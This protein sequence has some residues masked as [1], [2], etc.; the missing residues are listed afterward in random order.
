MIRS[1]NDAK[2]I[3]IT[4]GSA[5][6]ADNLKWVLPLIIAVLTVIAFY[7]AL[8]NV[9]VWD[10]EAGI[11]KNDHIRA[12]DASTLKWM[13]TTRYTG[14]Y[15]P[16]SWLS[17]AVDYQIW[18]SRLSWGIHLTT[19]A[20]HVATA[21]LFYL[22][23]RRLLAAAMPYGASPQR[24]LRDRG[25]YEVALSWGAATA[26]ALFAL[27]PLRV[28]S[29]A[30]A[31]ERRD[32]LS[33]FFFVLTILGYLRFAA[34]PER[35]TDRRLLYVLTLLSL[36]C[37]LLSKA[38]TV[39]LPLVLLVLDIYPLR[40]LQRKEGVRWHAG[41]ERI[42]AEKL[43]HL[44]LS[45]IIGIVA[46]TG[47]AEAGAMMDLASH[48]VL[49]R[50]LVAVSGIGFY[51]I[52]TVLPIGLSPMYELQPGFIALLLQTAPGA[53][54]AIAVI[55]TMLMLRRRF[56]GLATAWWC[57]VI[58]LLP[59]LGLVQVGVQMA[60][61]R[62]SYLPGMSLALAAGGSVLALLRRS[63]SRDSAWLVR[64]PIAVPVLIAVVLTPLTWR[65]CERWQSDII[66]WWHAVMTTPKS[67]VA[68]YNLGV[69]W[70]RRI[71]PDARTKA[72]AAYK[73]A[74][75]IRPDY[76]VAWQNLGNALVKE[77]RNKEATKAYRAALGLRPHDA[78][79]LANLGVA[80]MGLKE[81]DE[82]IKVLRQ[83]I[84]EDPKY[85]AAYNTLALVL[86]QKGKLDDAL[87]AYQKAIDA[88][89]QY[90]QAY[91][92]MFSLLMNR[93]M[94]GEAIRVLRSGT[95]SMPDNAEIANNL[96]WLLATCRD[97]EL[98]NGSEAV[99]LALRACQKTDFK[100]FGY[101]DTLAAA[102]AE[103][104]DF[105]K[106][107]QA[108]D[109]AIVLAETTNPTVASVLKNRR[110]EYVSGLPLRR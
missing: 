102:Y 99:Q 47:Q 70:D 101:L 74:V 83:A 9:F 34:A 86:V 41:T 53:L 32:V 76:Y 20:L 12:I 16:L 11:Q 17:L 60:A 8:D 58:L 50:L 7:P 106:A 90:V 6:P 49:A 13:F 29:V 66:L 95:R 110:Q 22:A 38:T 61:D 79:T 88:N 28:E 109:R 46:L 19:L 105:E 89:P 91:D 103:T 84:A 72:I 56:P 37:A 3:G 23:A 73:V 36:A 104:K 18:A 96:A 81:A 92:N 27:H 87:E 30:W 2:Q 100:K 45:F 54:V 65:Q 97:G 15:Q 14:P 43:P 55:V 80:L 75:N 4:A 71:A 62:Y 40:R 33:G 21:L 78:E 63:S 10:D 51:L 69:S 24:S 85:A 94:Y 64:A 48:G 26:M 108:I 42:L 31:T 82:A 44:A 59:T 107:V 35:S 93:H 25:Q 5:A 1:M 98:R 68:S 77:G 52:K 57:Y 67:A 39:T